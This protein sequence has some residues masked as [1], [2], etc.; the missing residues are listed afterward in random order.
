MT[1][2]NLFKEIFKAKS[3]KRKQVKIA[4]NDENQ[5][6]ELRSLQKVQRKVTS[7]TIHHLLLSR[8]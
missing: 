2:D 6:L 5:K 7:R 3:S 4:F 8:N 1:S